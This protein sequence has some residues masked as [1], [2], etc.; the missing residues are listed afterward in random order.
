MNKET[1]YTH[2]EAADIVEMVEELLDHYNI[3]V[4]SPEDD[5]REEDNCARLYGSVYY[6][7]L[8]A[9]EHNLVAIIQRAKNG[10]TV[11]EGV[12]APD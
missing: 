12:F 11:V 3:T 8:D 2:S 7:L 9:I 1:I 10:E 5:E 4:P 6:G